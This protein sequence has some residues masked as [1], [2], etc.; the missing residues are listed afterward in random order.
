MRWCNDQAGLRES[1]H[2]SGQSPEPRHSLAM[3]VEFKRAPGALRGP[4]IPAG[5]P[6]TRGLLG[7]GQNR[8][9]LQKET[10]IRKK[11]HQVSGED[12]TSRHETRESFGAEWS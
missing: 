7:S 2:P 9:S 12:K 4:Q 6:Q 10:D 5:P 8:A 11:R 1:F 3:A